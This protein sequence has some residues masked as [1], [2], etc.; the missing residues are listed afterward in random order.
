MP[1]GLKNVP[2]LFQTIMDNT[3]RPCNQFAIVYIDD[4]LIFS[5]SIE[6]HLECIRQTL[7]ALREA[8][9]KEKPQ[10]YDWGKTDTSVPGS[11]GWRWKWQY[12]RAGSQP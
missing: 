9:L 10:K 6:D 2:V 7:T 11:P 1:F 12:P 4:V 8:G 3:L 5:N